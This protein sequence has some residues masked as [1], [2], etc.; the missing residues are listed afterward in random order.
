MGR[1][2]SNHNAQS[3]NDGRPGCSKALGS[4]LLTQGLLDSLLRGIG[5]TPALGKKRV[6]VGKTRFQRTRCRDSP[7]DPAL[8]G[9]PPGRAPLDSAR[10]R[11]APGRSRVSPGTAWTAREPPSPGPEAGAGCAP[12][13]PPAA[14]LHR[15]PPRVRTRSPAPLPPAARLG[16]PGTSPPPPGR[17]P[18]RQR[19]P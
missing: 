10:V 6:F 4:Q 15:R 3:G 1:I 7:G 2:L 14:W 19:F 12:R 11:G 8:A 17:A 5:G 18:A 16:G 13:A 9:G